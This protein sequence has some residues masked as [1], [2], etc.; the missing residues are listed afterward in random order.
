MN[1]KYDYNGFLWEI[2]SYNCLPLKETCVHRIMRAGWL[3]PI[4][5]F[6]D[7]LWKRALYNDI[8]NTST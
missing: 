7:L 6:I 4:L 1:C 2:Q 8:G 5:D 3:W